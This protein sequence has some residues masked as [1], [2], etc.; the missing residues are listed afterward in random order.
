MSIPSPERLRYL[1]ERFLSDR[2]VDKVGVVV[3]VVRKSDGAVFMVE[4]R[5]QKDS[6]GKAIGSVNPPCET[7]K[8]CNDGYQEFIDGTV[9]AAL[10]T[11]MGISDV[12]QER[13]RFCY[14]DGFSF[15]GR[16]PFP[17]SS[18]RVVHADVVLLLY[19][20]IWDTFPPLNEVTP[21]GFLPLSEVIKRDDLRLGV[22]AILWLAC[23]EGWIDDFLRGEVQSLKRRQVF[24]QGFSIGR[25][26]DV[27]DN[28]VNRDVGE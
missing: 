22:Q 18:G 1:P 16:Y 2:G 10:A 19:D 24:P 23:T 9:R 7:R 26:L 21:V 13:T 14:L 17:T 12:C 5:E 25:F 20:G 27:R 28:P 3:L 11:E 4:E 15:K 8:E 6:T